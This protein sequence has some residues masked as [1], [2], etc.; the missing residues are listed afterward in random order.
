MKSP[1]TTLACSGLVAFPIKVRVLSLPS[2]WGWMAAMAS[3]FLLLQRQPLLSAFSASSLQA[4]T[5]KV[6]S[7]KHKCP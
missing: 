5:Q 2:L 1:A 3:G 7:S 6:G 4:N